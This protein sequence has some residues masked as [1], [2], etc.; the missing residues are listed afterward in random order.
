MKK[1]FLLSVIAATFSVAGYSQSLNSHAN[2]NNVPAK[3]T[4]D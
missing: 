2:A 3:V 4:H 1:L